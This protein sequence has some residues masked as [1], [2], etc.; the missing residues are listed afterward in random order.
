MIPTLA[1]LGDFINP[2][3][4]PLPEPGF[5]QR[6]V[7]EQPALPAVV[8]LIAGLVALIALRQ[9][10]A[11]RAGL[12]A[13]LTAALLAIALVAAGS[14]IDTDREQ[15]I[16]RQD[17]LVHAVAH[18]EIRELDRLLAP[19]ARVGGNELPVLRGGLD[20]EAILSTVRTY[21]GQRFTVST[22]GTIER[23]AV[24]DGPNAAR[25]QIYLRVVT[26]SSG[27]TWTWFRIGWR[28]GDDGQW[29]AVLVE[30]L[31]ISGVLAYNP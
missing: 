9:R 28:L 13:F 30:P 8:I 24:V 29:R 10:D 1:Q 17:R 11:F 27:Q 15:L 20:R 22:L 31:F 14:L 23:Q 26:E 25:T 5:V 12:I 2:N 18:A 21:L 7:L 4:A 3:V 6:F 16:A 19:D